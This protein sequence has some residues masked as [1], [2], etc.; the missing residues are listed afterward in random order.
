M[1]SI[2]VNSKGGFVLPLDLPDLRN[3]PLYLKA[4]EL[5][6][7]WILVGRLGPGMRL[8]ETTLATELGISRTPVR[9]ALRRLEQDR[10]IVAVPGSAYEVYLPTI[11]DVDD[12]YMA[13]AFLEGGAARQ[14]ARLGSVEPAKQMTLII[15]QMRQAY[16][17]QPTEVLL[18]L[19]TQFHDCLMAASGNS[20][21]MELHSHLTTRLCQ[22]RGMSGD[23]S[24]RQQLVLEQHTAIVEAIRLGDDTAAEE[25]TRTHILAVHA[26]AR[27]SFLAWTSPAP[28][29]A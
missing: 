4:Y 21:L 26:A 15:E 29:P 17:T 20:V 27:D 16:G 18:D 22:L 25:L 9:D 11:K 5:L 13:R 7:G 2:Q 10:L 23:V 6:K 24:V 28:T 1:S 12:L 8:R 14:A 3:D 19:D